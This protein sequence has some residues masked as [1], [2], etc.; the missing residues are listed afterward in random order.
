MDIFTS[1]LNGI[2]IYRNTSTPEDG[3]QFEE[4]TKLLYS[5]QDPNFINLETNATDIPSL[6]DIDGDGDLD[7]LC[8]GMSG[9]FHGKESLFFFWAGSWAANG[10]KM[11]GLRIGNRGQKLRR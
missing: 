2:R 9:G 3:L 6:D 1:N 10:I 11:D 7:I 5:F 4:A 8:F